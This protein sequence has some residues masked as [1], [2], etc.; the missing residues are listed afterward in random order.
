MKIKC[1]KCGSEINPKEKF[2]GICG[3]P[4]SESVEAVKAEDKGEENV[5]EPVEGTEAPKKKKF[6]FKVDGFKPIYGIVAGV[7]IIAAV[8]LCNFATV[9]NFCRKTFMSPSKYLAYVLA[10]KAETLSE[11]VADYYGSYV[12]GGLDSFDKE[13]K[14]EM[15]LSLGEKGSSLVASYSEDLDFLKNVGIN[16]KVSNKANKGEV[17][18]EFL[19]NEQSIISLEGL[20]DMDEAKEYI[21]FPELSS[22]YVLLKLEEFAGED[23]EEEYKPI[24][25]AAQKMADACPTDAEVEKLLK[26]YAKVALVEYDSVKKDSRELKVSKVSQKCTMLKGDFTELDLA[27]MSEA[28]LKEAIDDGKLKSLL[29]KIYDSTTTVTEE[30]GIYSETFDSFYAS[31]IIDCEENLESIQSEIES[32]EN[33]E[34]EDLTVFFSFKVYV[35]KKGDVRGVEIAKDS[36]SLV[37]AVAKNG[38]DIGVAFTYSEKWGDS[39]EE[40]GIKGKG[41]DVK[42]IVSGKFSLV[43]ENEDLLSF[44][45][46]KFDFDEFKKGN[47]KGRFTTEITEDAIV[48]LFGRSFYRS[49]SEIF[50]G[51]GAIVLDADMSQK[52]GNFALTAKLGSAELV[53]LDFSYKS[54]KASGISVPADSKCVEFTDS[55]SIMAYAE[56]IKGDKLIKALRKAGVPDDYV[57][58]VEEYFNIIEDNELGGLLGGL[59]Y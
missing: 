38:D 53:T 44:S 9:S 19:L 59:G 31:F 49:I 6:V 15:K 45:V 55:A 18:L 58:E 3:T 4:V 12:L 47:I 24:I 34:K 5:S 51:K 50:S 8:V 21:R 29:Q 42:G 46:E 39:S 10:Q 22:K 26:K 43:L 52:S 28:V 33:A 56:T 23:I 37:A 14:G 1:I 54:G 17:A 16:Y 25:D 2:C 36:E 48:E 40:T 11:S 27:R 35:D 13:A 7:V 57:D 41:T 20:V 32:L 30:V